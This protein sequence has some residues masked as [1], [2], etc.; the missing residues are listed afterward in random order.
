VRDA[1][2]DAAAGDIGSLLERS[3]SVRDE[4]AAIVGLPA[5]FA[6]FA[7]LHGHP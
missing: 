7:E 5:S 1:L 6:V 2:I 3:R 4:G